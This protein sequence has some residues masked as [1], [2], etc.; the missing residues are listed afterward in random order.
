[1]MDFEVSIPTRTAATRI[2]E[3]TEHVNDLDSTNEMSL[4]KDPVLFIEKNYYNY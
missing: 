3:I 1:M 2:T 4:G